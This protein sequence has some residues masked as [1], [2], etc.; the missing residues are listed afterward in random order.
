MG[1]SARLRR[2]ADPLVAAL[3]PVPKVALFPLLLIVFGLGDTPR[4]LA[5]AFAAFFPILISTLTGVRHI[6][7][8]YFE[9]ARNYEV[10]AWRVLRQVVIPGSLPQALVGLRLGLNTALLVTISVELLSARVG[11]GA[12]IWRARETF[13]L[14]ELYVG[15]AGSAILGVSFH[16]A[17]GWL[18]RR[19]VR[20]R[21][22][23]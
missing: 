18:T 16:A 14:E 2:V 19:L 13:R 15:L 5:S 4:I 10:P 22:V 9:V 17:V 8:V 11:F 6:E 3:H 23:E 20:W 1:W 21:E 12:L 7:P